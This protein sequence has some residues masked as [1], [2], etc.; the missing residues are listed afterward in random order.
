MTDKLEDGTEFGLASRLRFLIGEK[1]S[2]NFANQV[3]V[4]DSTL[5]S[6]LKGTRPS[7]DFVVTISDATGAS[8]EWLAT[9]RGRPFKDEIAP[10]ALGLN[11]ELYEMIAQCVER[12]FDSVGVKLPTGVSAATIID[13]YDEIIDVASGDDFEEYRSLLPWLEYG[14]RKQAEHYLK[15]SDN[16]QS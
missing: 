14:L 9:G 4:K 12:V 13:C 3:G 2:R 6:V 5:R 7:I 10:T 15:A 11:R 16:G 1:P 8:L